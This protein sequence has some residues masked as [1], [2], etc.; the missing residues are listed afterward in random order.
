MLGVG[1]V[2]IPIIFPINYRSM[3][4]DEIIKQ[5]TFTDMWGYTYNWT[6]NASGWTVDRR[7]QVLNLRA[8]MKTQMS[9]IPHFTKT[10]IKKTKMP[11]EL[12]QYILENRNISKGTKDISISGNWCNY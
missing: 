4:E 2:K 8:E 3:H 12:H 11:D 6:D 7:R 10:G 1:M 9:E 5:P